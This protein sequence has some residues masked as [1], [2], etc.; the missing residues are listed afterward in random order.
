[1]GIARE[2]VRHQRYPGNGF[3]RRYEKFRRPLGACWEA[4][5]P[6]DRFGCD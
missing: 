4:M 3:D 2:T 6:G 5:A 1:M